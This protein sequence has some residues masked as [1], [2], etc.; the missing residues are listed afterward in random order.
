M[1]C[2]DAQRPDGGFIIR[3]NTENGRMVMSNEKGHAGAA[4]SITPP[5]IREFM[6]PAVIRGYDRDTVDAFLQEAAYEVAVN[7]LAAAER[8]VHQLE[9]LCATGME[10]LQ[11]E[12]RTYREREHAVG[13]AL[14]VAQQ[15]A[16][17]LRSKAEQDA[18]AIRSA[19]AT[20][21]EGLRSA[22]KGEAESIIAQAR[23]Q[24]TKIEE[25]AS[26]ARSMFE[27]ELERLRSLKEATQHDLAEFLAQALRGLQES[28]DHDRTSPSAARDDE[29]A[30]QSS[31]S[32]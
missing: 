29:E 15:V 27:G 21:V 14:V 4:H 30:E 1:T 17:E 11:R 6:A 9:T 13:A 32:R 2:S 12:L 20:D 28:V 8:R 19:A 31:S 5:A 23:L 16:S 25:D 18:E 26:S 10:V 24:A 7:D 22:A 3:G